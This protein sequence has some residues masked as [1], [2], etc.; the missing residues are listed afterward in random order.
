[1][2]RFVIYAILL[3]LLIRV[4]SRFWKSV[5]EGMGGRPDPRG[6]VPQ[7]GVDLVRDPV[8]GTFVVRERAVML[9]AG[10][11]HLYFCSVNCRDKY[12]S[13]TA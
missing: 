2:I 11:D 10:R 7:R 6:S 3:S 1:M 12:R 9:S 13:K 4:L 5:V 8:C